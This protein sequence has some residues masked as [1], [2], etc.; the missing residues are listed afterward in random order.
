[1][2]ANKI[3]EFSSPGSSV[4]TQSLQMPSS[5]VIENTGTVKTDRFSQLE[6]QVAELTTAISELKT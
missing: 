6:V 2:M 1:M 3:V 4:C 5:H